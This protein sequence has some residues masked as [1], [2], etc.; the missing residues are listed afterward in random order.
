MGRKYRLLVPRDGRIRALNY[1][2][3]W[4]KSNCRLARNLK[5]KIAGKIMLIM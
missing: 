5:Q 2:S 1:N 4:D 3:Y